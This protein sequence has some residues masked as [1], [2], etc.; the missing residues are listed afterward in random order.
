[1]PPRVTRGSDPVLKD[2][3]G[4]VRLSHSDGPHIVL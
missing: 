3:D 2:P 4:G 1:M